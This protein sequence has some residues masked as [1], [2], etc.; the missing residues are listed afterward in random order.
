MVKFMS[1]LNINLRIAEIEKK[2][3]STTGVERKKLEEELGSLKFELSNRRINES[4]NTTMSLF[5]VIGSLF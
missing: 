4:M 1:T 5:N 2:L 3:P